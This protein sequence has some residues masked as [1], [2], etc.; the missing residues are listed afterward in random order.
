MEQAL[1]PETIAALHSPDAGNVI[2]YE[3]ATTLA[4]YAVDNGVELRIC[5][6]VA[7]ITKKVKI[8]EVDVCHWGRKAYGNA[9]KKMG[10]SVDGSEPTS[11][12]GKSLI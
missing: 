3:S 8:F 7:D 10:K 6:E 2:P 5:R 4:E 11:S 12:T 9:S 1:N